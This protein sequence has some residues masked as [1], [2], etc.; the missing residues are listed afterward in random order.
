MAAFSDAPSLGA[1]RTGA[2]QLGSRRGRL[3]VCGTQATGGGGELASLTRVLF[4]REF[5]RLPFWALA[6]SPGRATAGVQAREP[7]P[8]GAW[9]TEA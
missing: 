8:A 3:E 1:G 7:P 4:V 6:L 2:A 5:C 9:G